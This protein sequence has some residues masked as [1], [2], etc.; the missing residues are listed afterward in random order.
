MYTPRGRGRAASASRA[1]SRLA[2]AASS[3]GLAGA[4][5]GPRS[6]GVGISR[7]CELLDQALDPRR[8]GLRVDAVDRRHPLALEQL[9]DLLVG[10]DHQ[11]LDQAVGLGLRRPRGAP[12]TSPAGVELE[13]GLGRLDLEAW[14]A[15]AARRAA[16]AP[17]A[18]APAARR[19]PRARRSRPAKTRRAGRSRGAR[20]SGS[21]CG[22]SC[23]A[24]RRRR[25]RSSISAVTASRS[26]PGA[27]LQASSLSAARQHR[28]DRPRRRR[29][30]WRAARAS[31]SSARAR[32][33]RG[34]RR[35]RCGSR[36]GSPSPSRRAET[37]SSKSRARRRVD[38][39]GRQRRSG[40]G[41]AVELRSAASAARLASAS[42]EVGK[43]RRPSSSRSSRLDRVPRV[44]RLRCG[45]AAAGG[46]PRRLNP[47]PFSS[48][49]DL[50][51]AFARLVAF[52]PR[53]RRGPRRPGGSRC[54]RG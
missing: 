34:R 17:R 2:S 52:G 36:A 8:V 15:R 5:I 48:G 3:P 19:P 33:R 11:P 18:R 9:R 45:A 46:P 21:G 50:E 43:P 16:A 44:L 22:R 25:R 29:C 1:T 26:T 47:V 6:G 51:G 4:E 28:L 12:T 10:E 20:R 30:C 41:A 49:E 13:L 23:A 32:A 42:S 39:E 40:R 35:R 54:R 31:R 38:G 7:S 14:S 53:D 37:A 27:R 24:R